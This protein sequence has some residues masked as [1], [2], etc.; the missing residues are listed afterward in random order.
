MKKML[1]LFSIFL[2]TSIQT[3]ADEPR[4]PTVVGATDP[5]S[6]SNASNA[7]TGPGATESV[8]ELNPDESLVS[9][10]GADTINDYDPEADEAREPEGA[11]PVQKD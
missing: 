11:T 8:P 1:L 5:Q 2:S 4:V 10:D 3:F 9:G 7:Q 6:S